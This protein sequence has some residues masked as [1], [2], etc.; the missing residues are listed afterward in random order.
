L[1]PG[2]RSALKGWPPRMYLAHWGLERSPFA[3][4]ADEPLFYE[5]DSQVEA[6]AR[7]RFVVRD[8]RRAAVI[9]GGRGVGKSR[10]VRQ[11]AEECRRDGR[12]VAA[13]S[14]AGTSARE[15][16][17]QVASQWAIGPRPADD[18]VALF[19]RIAAAL[20]AQ[21]WQQSAA[22]VLLDDADLAGPDVRAYVQRLVQVS[23]G[24]SRLSI[25]MSTSSDAVDRLGVELLEAVDLRV[26]LEPWS[27]SECVG[28]VQHALLEAG[29]DRPAFDDEA[30]ETLARLSGGVPRRLNRLADHALLAAAAEELEEASAA[31]IEAANDALA[32]LVP[33]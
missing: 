20:D 7:L 15:A 3:D 17:W 12:P 16:L 25:V 1:C 5:G 10:L 14:L 27:E 6:L 2:D 13:A 11:F 9:C 33:A 24:G 29:C 4:G 30:L 31:T 26:D 23:G 19:R 22:V 8:G 18:A 21:R 28:Y 32:W